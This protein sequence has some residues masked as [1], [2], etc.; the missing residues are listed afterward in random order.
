MQDEVG[1]DLGDLPLDHVFPDD[2]DLE[3]EDEVDIDGEP[4]FEDELA[5]QVVGVQPKRKRSIQ[6]KAYTMTEDK[7]L[8]IPSFGG[9][10][11]PT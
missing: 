1:L 6:M 11:G 8:C 7:L 4:S 3:E 2:Y 5:N 10:Q 9:I